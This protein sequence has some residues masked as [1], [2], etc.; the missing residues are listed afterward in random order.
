MTEKKAMVDIEHPVLSISRQCELLGLSRS[1]F[2]YQPAKA[3]EENLMLMEEIDRLYLKYPFFGTRKMAQ[4]LKEQGYGVNRKRVKRLYQLMGI[5]AI[6]PKPN[7]SKPVKGHKIYPYL[8]RNL[9]IDRVNQVWATDLTYIPM[10]KGFMYLMAVI[11][12]YSRKAISWGVSNSMDTDFCCSVL[13]EALLTGMPEVFNTDQ[14]SQ[15]TSDAFTDVLKEQGI[16]ISMDGKGRATDNIFIERLWRSLK[17]EYLYLKRPE[18]CQELYKGVEAYFQFYNQ[19]RLHQSLKYKTP[20][21]IYS[22]HRVAA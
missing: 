6:G 21:S 10:P 17:Y 2:Y 4:V 3:N 22:I 14:G 18:T 12:L 5:Q 7:T 15:F 20:E 19:E 13:K 1:V 8:L 16:Q 11:D 9:R